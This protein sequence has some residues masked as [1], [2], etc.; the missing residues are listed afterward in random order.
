VRTELALRY[1]LL[2][3]LKK[4]E[5]RV[6]AERFL[7]VTRTMAV[8]AEGRDFVV[9]WSDAGRLS[10]QRFPRET[11]DFYGRGDREPGRVDADLQTRNDE[12]A[13]RFADDALG[14]PHASGRAATPAASIDPL[15]GIDWAEA[16]A[17][18]ATGVA[19]SG[20][21]AGLGLFALRA[22][23]LGRTPLVGASAML[24][25]AAVGPPFAALL[26]SI[27]TAILFALRPGAS[28]R[29][30]E[31]ALGGA[32]L[33]SSVVRAAASGP[34]PLS[35]S[36]LLAASVGAVVVTVARSLFNGHFQALQ[37]V[38]PSYL[39]G[40]AVDGHHAAAMVSLAVLLAGVVLKAQLHRLVPVQRERAL[41]P[42][43]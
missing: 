24:A 18:G 28:H 13:A 35:L 22:S 37:L 42:N 31:L 5:R 17:L 33:V 14:L 39:L 32:A 19:S 20:A 23:D 26:G 38:I 12:R 40:L 7:E 15:A 4:R 3:H 25:L 11:F 36:W 43:G 1:L 21:L 27:A 10:Q 9:T 2:R 29:L 6:P 8:T 41:T 30:P 16:L 34:A